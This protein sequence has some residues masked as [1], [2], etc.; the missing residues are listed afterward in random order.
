MYV[1]NSYEKQNGAEEKALL[2]EHHTRMALEN[3]YITLSRI[4]L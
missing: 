2:V 4:K 1:L 3:I